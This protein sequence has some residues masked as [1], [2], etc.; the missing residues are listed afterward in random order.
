M[1]KSHINKT[2]YDNTTNSTKSSFEIGSYFR[3]KTQEWISILA[4]CDGVI[5]CF[6]ASD[7]IEDCYGG[8]F[9]DLVCSKEQFQCADGDCIHISQVCNFIDDCIDGSDEYCEI[10]QCSSLTEFR[11]N[12]G[13]CI[14]LH[15][16]CDSVQ[17]CND[18][19]DEFACE[20]CQLDIAFHCDVGRCIPMRLKC[21][22][23]DHCED[24]TDEHACGNRVY[25]SCQDVWEAGFR[26]SGYYMI[27]NVKVECMFGDVYKKS[28]ITTVFTFDFHYTSF[29]FYWVRFRE[30]HFYNI[31]TTAKE[32]TIN[33]AIYNRDSSSC[34]QQLKP[35]RDQEVPVPTA[36]GGNF[37]IFQPL[38]N[39]SH[40]VN[41]R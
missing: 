10:V 17:H 21:D 19:S 40:I 7:E 15:Q 23:Y 36:E 35:R 4:K 31:P 37:A 32:S 5:D 28:T 38:K 20:E 14:P 6:D 26:K 1:M 8:N 30:A 41:D 25:T 34:I 24:G 33:F 18:G 39:T 3:C 27:G 11:C 2:T 22:N 9:G 12:D 29:L 13:L 16:R